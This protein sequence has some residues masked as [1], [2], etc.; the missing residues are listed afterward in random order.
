LLVLAVGAG[1]WNYAV[2]YRADLESPRD[3][4]F[5]PYSTPE[6]LLLE[7]AYA[8]EVTRTR[9]L[10][11][12]RLERAKAPPRGQAQPQPL[13]GRVARLE[14]AQ[15]AAGKAR[16]AQADFAENEARLAEVQSELDR[17]SQPL[18]GLRVHLE[19]LVRRNRD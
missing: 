11:E 9:E 17:R 3:L 5:A 19:R 12:E 8:A 10:Y 15:A 2:S 7:E 18:A 14:R 1:G 16:S 13:A 4:P 6:L